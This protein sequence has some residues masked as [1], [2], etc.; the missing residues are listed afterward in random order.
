MG[1]ERPNSVRS[2]EEKILEAILK[3]GITRWAESQTPKL[4][5]AQHLN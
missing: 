4:G 3:Y 1:W 5:L 2:A